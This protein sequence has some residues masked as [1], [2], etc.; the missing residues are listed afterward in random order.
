MF[1]LVIPL[2][3]EEELVDELIKRVVSAVETFDPEYEIILVDDG[4]SDLTLEK[5]LAFREKNRKIKVISLSRNFGHQAAYTAGLEHSSGNVVAMMDGDLQ[6]P[7]E[8]LPDMYRKIKQEGFDVI[9][10]K[11]T[12]RKGEK[13]RNLYM[14][15]FHF[16]F[17]KIVEIK[18]MD[19]YGNF[20][21]MTREALTAMLSMKERIRYLPGLRTIVGF[22]QGFVEFVRDD[23][24][25]GDP[26]M[27]PGKL[28]N[29]A[30]D[31]IFSFSK[32]PL[33][34]CLILG[35]LGTIVFF[36]A[37]IYVL[38]AKIWGFAVMGWS[39]TLLS[40]Y[41]LGSIQLVFMGILGEYVYRNYKES[42]FRPLYF[43]KK[44]YG[45]AE[46]MQ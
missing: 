32:F 28:F 21:M 11:R 41:F 31:A 24:F 38:V 6:D 40:I 29:L 4:S 45:I 43:I 15:L 23:R 18:G 10:G 2:Y 3:N 34:V 16:M 30:F 9:N 14:T 42:Q 8:I 13:R 35:I 39:S 12:G 5:I 25:K 1:S 26:K 27:S 44:Y 46:G 19:D 37:G 36:S 20:S 22:K 7:P 33:R 17:R